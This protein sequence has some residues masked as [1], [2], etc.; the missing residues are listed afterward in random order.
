M[1]TETTPMELSEQEQQLVEVLREWDH[2]GE[3]RLTIEL[4]GVWDV[5]LQRQDTGVRAVRGTGPTFAEAWDAMDIAPPD[6]QAT[7]AERI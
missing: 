3:Y 7:S 2:V 6:L 1:V 4:H 5:A